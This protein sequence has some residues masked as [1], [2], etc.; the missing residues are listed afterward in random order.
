M[1]TYPPLKLNSII[2]LL[3]V[4][5]I[6]SSVLMIPDI[7]KLNNQ[8]L[9]MPLWMLQI[10][11]GVQSSI[12]FLIFIFIGSFC[13]RKVWLSAPLIENLITQ[14]DWQSVAKRQLKPAIIAGAI[15]SIV[16]IVFAALITPHLPETFIQAGKD[17]QPS[18]YARIFYGGICEEVLMRWGFLSLL[19]W[20]GHKFFGTKD[21]RP[22][23]SLYFIAIILSALLFALA[24]LP[25]VYALTPDVN[26]TLITYIIVG[27]SIAGLIAGYLFCQYGLES[28]IFSHITFHLVFMLANS[29]TA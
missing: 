1:Q 24:H 19:V 22:A 14:Q 25:T 17:F 27:N 9:P 10:I 3:C 7:L 29:V 13:A 2:F 21:S 20:L 18:W 15:G 6:I 26:A 23:L 12:L 5:G 28:A 11:S 4:P 8:E 16:I